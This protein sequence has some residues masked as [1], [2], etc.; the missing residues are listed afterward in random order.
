MILG[1]VDEAVKSGASQE[2]VCDLLEISE[3]ALQR[4]RKQGIGDDNRAGAKAAPKN[5]LA[6]NERQEVLSIL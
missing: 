1:F 5:K 2:G 4:W 6:D 3:R